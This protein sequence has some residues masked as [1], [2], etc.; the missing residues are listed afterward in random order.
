[1]RREAKQSTVTVTPY[2]L[3]KAFCAAVCEPNL[4]KSWPTVTAEVNVASTPTVSLGVLSL[5]V[6]E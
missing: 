5:Q 3:S 2:L 4:S 1:M 6:I